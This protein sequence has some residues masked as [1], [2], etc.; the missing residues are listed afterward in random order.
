M[1]EKILKVLSFNM[2]FMVYP[3]ALTERHKDFL[4]TVSR[5]NGKKRTKKCFLILYTMKQ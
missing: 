1:K 3:G 4:G 2:E 5:E